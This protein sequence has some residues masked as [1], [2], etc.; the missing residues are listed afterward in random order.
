MIPRNWLDCVVA[1]LILL[2]I[3]SC[4]ALAT[5]VQAWRW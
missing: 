1:A 2:G 5:Y 4:L 3:L